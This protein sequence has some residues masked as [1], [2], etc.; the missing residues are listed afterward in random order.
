MT[1]RVAQISDTH[2]SAE[3]PF[4]VANFKRIGE[5]LAHELPDLVINTG[6]ISLDGASGDAD[7]AEARRRHD[8]MQVSYLCIPGNHD[9]GDNVDVPAVHQTID[10]ERRA[11]YLRHF[12]RD[13]W[14]VDVPGWRLIG[15]NAQLFESGLDAAREQTAFIAETVAGAHE[16]RIALFV[17][18]PLF[19]RRE[20]E[21]LVGGRFLNPSSRRELLGAFGALR[22]ALVACGHVHQFRETEVEGGRHVWAPSTAYHIPDTRQPRYGQKEVGFVIHDLRDDGTHAS[23]FVIAPGT[24][25]LCIADFPD[26]YG[27]I[28]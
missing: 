14:H 28:H 5:A 26:A 12:G 23:R 25:N 18:K 2:L 21:D 27:P 6:D 13:W 19:D 17:H 10:A 3:K 11:R 15:L 24:Q 1:F 16:R 9:L 7:L 8:A 20:D 22:P 4:F